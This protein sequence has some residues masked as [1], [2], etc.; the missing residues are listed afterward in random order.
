MGISRR[1][2]NLLREI[3]DE[4]LEAQK[5]LR[6]IRALAWPD[7]VEREFFA[8]GAAA[9]PRPSYNIPAGVSEALVRFQSLARRLDGENE[10]ERF[11]RETCVAMAT[12]ARMLLAIGSRD[13]YHNSIE[14]YGR[15]ASLSSDRRTT[16]LDLARHFEQVIAGYSPPLSDV[17]QP[18]L[19]ADEAAD[20]LRG[21]FAA[22]FTGHPVKVTIVDHRP[23]PHR[24]PPLKF[25]LNATS[26]FPSATCAKSKAT[27]AMSTWRPR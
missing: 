15:P 16:N 12:A 22:F 20:F 2:V 25:G 4:I 3:S 8:R 24:A 14:L 6:V 10:I 21:R 7:E 9:L 1:L 13:F 11:L 17:D 19:G 26:A 27:R 5:P 23:P 18:T